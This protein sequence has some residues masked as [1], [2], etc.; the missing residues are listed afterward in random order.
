MEGYL[1][2]QEHS[3]YDFMIDC[4]TVDGK[5]KRLDI[6]INDRAG[7]LDI[8]RLKANTVENRT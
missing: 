4:V 8:P 2:A 5:M 1:L 7:I 3:W 6:A